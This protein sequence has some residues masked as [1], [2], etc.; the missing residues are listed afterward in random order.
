MGSRGVPKAWASSAF[1][2]ASRSP[3]SVVPR[4][5]YYPL[6]EQRRDLTLRYGMAS[7]LRSHDELCGQRALSEIGHEGGAKHNS[8]IETAVKF[9]VDRRSG[10]STQWYT[11]RDEGEG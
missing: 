1:G 6:S 2:M 11:K 7:R 8:K 5:V 10:T 4:N 9:G 3:G